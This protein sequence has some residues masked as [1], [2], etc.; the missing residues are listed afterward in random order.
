MNII[1]SSSNK[2]KV[3]EIQ[4]TLGNNYNL[5][6][7][8]QIGLGDI[9]V[10][11]DGQ[12]LE[13]NSYKKAM[14][15]FEK[16]K[17]ATLADDTGL[18]V[19]A[20]DMRPGVYSARYAGENATYEENV[21]KMLNELKDIKDL[22]K[23]KA[24]FKTVVCFIDNQGK[25]HFVEGILKGKIIFERKGQ[26]GFGYDPIFLPN[27]YETTL[28]QITK[29]EKNKISHRAKALANLKKLLGDRL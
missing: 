15:I 3:K 26:N 2:D 17:K 11:E 10:V 24:F 7:K 5:I 8:D 1:V 25:E 12:T 28:A 9:D 18:F 21:D 19:E 23:R 14:A 4:D 22:N 13:E 27:G 20:L 29:E 6:L 16:T